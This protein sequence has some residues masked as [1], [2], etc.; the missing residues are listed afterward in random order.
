[1]PLEEKVY[2]IPLRQDWVREPRISRVNVS[3]EKIRFFLSK[4]SKTKE[5]KISPLL[6]ESLWIRGAQK[7]PAFVKVKVVKDEKGIV[8]AMLP[9]EK[10]EVTE[11]RGL[12]HKLLRRKGEKSSKI[13]MEGK[14]NETEKA[15]LPTP[16]KAEEK[17]PIG[18]KVKE[19]KIA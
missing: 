14:T 3:V 8:N 1:M 15:A 12:K 16:K 5:I 7:P 17:E 10:L 19:E 11:K 13:V 4:H 2:K 6:N 9:E 18:E